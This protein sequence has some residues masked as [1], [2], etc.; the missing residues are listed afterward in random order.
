MQ[1]LRL[2]NTGV[3]LENTF[4][5][6]LDW[7]FFIVVILLLYYVMMF[8]TFLVAN[9]GSES[10]FYLA[11]LDAS[12]NLCLAF[13]TSLPSL[14]SYFSLI[15]NSSRVMSLCSNTNSLGKN[16]GSQLL[17]FLAYDILGRLGAINKSVA[18][19]F[20]LIVLR[21]SLLRLMT[22]VHYSGIRL[23]PL[24]F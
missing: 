7:S 20:S 12:K 8:F 1:T 3:S 23:R 14:Y 2:S 17:T 16:K 19:D 5:Y 4:K 11:A 9:L 10:S 18:S 15:L 13:V 22:P 6:V 21:L 24:V